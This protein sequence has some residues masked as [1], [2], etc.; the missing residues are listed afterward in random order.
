MTVNDAQPV[1]PRR[2]RCPLD[3]DFDHHSVEYRESIP[4]VLAEMHERC[5]VV[6]SEQ[7]GGFYMFAR[8][9]DVVRIV[10]DHETF[11]SY[12]D[13]EGTGNGGQGAFIPQL[14]VRNGILETDP[15]IHRQYR[16]L[17]SK[18]F[19]PSAIAAYEG[20]M[21][22]IMAD[23]IESVRAMETFDVVNDLANPVTAMLTLDFAGMGLED[24]EVYVRPI[25]DQA[26]ITSASP[27]FPSHRAA[28]ER[29]MGKLIELIAARRA[30]PRDDL[31]SQLIVAEIDGEPMSDAKIVE[32]L[33]NLMSGGFDTTSAT[34]AY[35]MRHLTEHPAERARLASDRGLIPH[36]V[37][38]FIRHS[39]PSNQA[40]RTVMRETTVGGIAL[41]PGD[42]VM[43]NWTAA[44]Y[45]PT[46]FD[47]PEALR[48]DRSPNRHLAF[49][50]GI[51][52]CAG[53]RFARLELRLFLEEL[54]E[55]MPNF[56]VRTQDTVVFPSI[57]FINGFVSMTA[58]AEAATP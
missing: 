49:G 55:R 7:Y 24:W 25:H 53:T 50:D 11:S 1:T 39:S 15:P 6:R 40:S 8:Y 14:P 48:L 36:A 27:D 3:A 22:E 58:I 28:A 21:R 18:W 52:R 13:L 43:V 4:A 31:V 20:R 5:P 56:A 26:Y 23:R 54:F 12:N 2:S 51:H 29:A 16:S 41:K 45:D 46:R 9:E 34:I 33:W 57:G 10:R 38:E 32:F 37:E 47:A 35:I 44:N 19:S 17:F 42:R 30:E